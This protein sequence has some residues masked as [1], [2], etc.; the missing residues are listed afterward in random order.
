MR[1]LFIGGTGIISSACAELA[2]KRGWELY[3]LRRGIS[4]A[5]PVMPGTKTIQADMYG[6]VDT[7]HERLGDLAFDVV[8]DFI[9]Y[10]TADIERD[11]S[12]FRGRTKQFM[13]ISSASAYQKPPTHYVITEETPLINP[14]WEYSRDKIACEER[15]QKAFREEAF[16]AVIIRPSHTYSVAYMPLCIGSSAHPFTMIR[17]MRQGK[18]MIVPG[19]G[20]S[21]WTLT[22]NGDFAKGLVGLMGRKDVLGEAFHITSD[23]A[24]TWN[25]IYQEAG[26]AAGV[27]PNLIHIPSTWLAAYDDA[28][29]GELIGDKAHCAVFDN[30]K[31]KRYVPDFSAEV[32]WAEGIRRSVA[33][34]DA[35]LSRQT[36]DQKADQT[37][38][39]MIALYETA[40]PKK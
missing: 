6:S 32:S 1:A 11:I 4:T 9:A 24:L 21:L 15:L 14:F 39:E 19:D 23:V 20:T 37:W 10:K 30:A 28:M 29:I 12:I 35:D 16:P 7:I 33:W 34:L 8:V 22:W 5:H 38:D 26:R 3:L 25:Q 18:K 17:R 27:E 2:V 31:I 40:W 13:F 36:I